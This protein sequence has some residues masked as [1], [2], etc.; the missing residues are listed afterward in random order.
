[1]ART[2]SD[3]GGFTLLE[4]LLAMI[5]LAVGGVSIMSLYAAAVSKQYDSVLSQ[6]KA[7][8]YR[9]I[10][11]EAQQ[12]LDGH[13]PTKENPLPPPMEKRPAAG[14]R[15]FKVSVEFQGAGLFPPGEGAVAV[16]Q[17]YLNEEALK[18]PM[19]SVLQR[20]V[21]SEQ[22]LQKNLSYDRDRLADEAAKEK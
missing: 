15:D 17:L 11:A 21:F 8:I 5:V 12:V 10:V 6:R 1:M 19:R 7:L 2:K 9:D 13:T 18:E 22:E 4:V 20:T 16:I 14:F 3:E